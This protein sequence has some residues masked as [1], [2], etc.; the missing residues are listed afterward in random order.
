MIA[1][2]TASVSTRPAYL[3]R[4]ND[5][6]RSAWR[7]GCKCSAAPPLGHELNADE[8]SDEEAKDR[9]RRETEVLDD[10]HVL[11]AVSW[12]MRNDAPI[13]RIAKSARL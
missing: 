8:D 3:P 12:P 1:R 6:G 10:L 4:T 7:A 11:P 2:F 13:S 9:G 5:T